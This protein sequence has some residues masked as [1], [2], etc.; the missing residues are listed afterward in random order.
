MVRDFFF[1]RRFYFLSA[2]RDLAFVMNATSESANEAFELMKQSIKYLIYK[3]KNQ[4][5][6]YQILIHGEDSSAREISFTN[7]FTDIKALSD[8]VDQLTRN[9][10]VNLPALHEDLEKVGEAFDKISASRPDSEKVGI[11]RLIVC[12]LCLNELIRIQAHTFVHSKF[13]KGKRTII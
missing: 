13:G 6:N 2:E 5:M 1:G 7:D 3:Q 12:Y 11:Q 4:R 10:E 8:S 9:S